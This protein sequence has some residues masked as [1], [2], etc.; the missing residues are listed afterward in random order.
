MLLC[1]LVDEDCFPYSGTTEK[2]RIPRRGDLRSAGCDLPINVERT[3]KYRT[4]PAYRLGNETDIMYEIY[5]SGPVQGKTKKF[6][7]R[8]SINLAIFFCI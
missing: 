7:N 3:D 5:K 2:C 1:S 6:G 8:I 4:A